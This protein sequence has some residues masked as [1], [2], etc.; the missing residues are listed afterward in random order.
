M[1][2]LFGP[3][4]DYQK[5]ACRRP[6]RLLTRMCDTFSRKRLLVS[7]AR[8]AFLLAEASSQG[9]SAFLRNQPPT[10]PP[11]SQI[12]TNKDILLSST[13]RTQ[14]AVSH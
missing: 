1:D 14:N 8:G 7:A 6:D 4:A 10:P 13:M 12:Q 2:V 3:Y 5:S 11:F 9:I